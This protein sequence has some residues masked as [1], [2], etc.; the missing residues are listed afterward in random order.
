MNSSQLIAWL[1]CLLLAFF[2]AAIALRNGYKVAIL[3]SRFEAV[4]RAAGDQTEV[5]ARI[6]GVLARIE[7]HL[8]EPAPAP[9]TGAPPPA[10]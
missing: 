2:A 8:S 10:P 9:E 6:E 1:L 3:E 4:Q 7:E 5:L